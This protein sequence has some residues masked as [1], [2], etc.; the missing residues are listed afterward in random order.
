MK[1]VELDEAMLQQ[2]DAT[3]ILVDHGYYDLEQIVRHSKLVIDTRDATGPLGPRPTV[4]K[5]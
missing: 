5:F 1:S 4:V 3:V 2:H